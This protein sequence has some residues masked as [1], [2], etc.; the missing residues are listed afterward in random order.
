[1]N[2]PALESC[3]Q[4]SGTGRIQSV[5][6]FSLSWTGRKYSGQETAKCG[7]C[8]N[9][10]YIR[11]IYEAT[12]ALC[13]TEYKI[14]SCEASGHPNSPTSNNCTSTRETKCSNCSGSGSALPLDGCSH[15]LLDSHPYCSH[16][17]SEQH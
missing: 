8:G 12:C 3:V 14:S 1:M 9:T 16:G 17:Y 6:G 10:S 4:C 11:K 2:G 5:C 7:F 15:G 13:S